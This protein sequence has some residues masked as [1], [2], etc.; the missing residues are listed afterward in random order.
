MATDEMLAHTPH[1]R[2]RNLRD[3]RDFLA[4]DLVAHDVR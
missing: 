2:I 3:Y 1:D 4:A